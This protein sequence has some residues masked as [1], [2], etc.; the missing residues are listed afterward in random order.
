MPATIQDIA[1]KLKISKTTVH[2]ALS[3]TGR[4]SKK[5]EA[6][7][8]ETAQEVDYHPNDLARSMRNQK[9]MTI[10]LIFKDLK[11]GHFYSEILSGI[12]EIATKQGYVLN[13]SFSGN[14]P[15]KEKSAIYS[16]CQRRIDGLIIAPVNHSIL[17]N[18]TFLRNQKIPFVF[19]DKYVEEI[20]ADVIT[21]DNKIGIGQAVK[22]LMER[23]HTRIAFLSGSEYPSI[24]ILKRLQAYQEE[25]DH[26]HLYFKKVLYSEDFLGDD[27][28]CGY[29]AVNEY[30]S[31]TPKD[32]W[33][34]AMICVNDSLAFGAIRAIK[35]HNLSI[36]HDMAI[37]G[38]NNDPMS[39]FVS[40]RLT[41]LSQPKMEMGRAVSRLLL[42]R[43]ADSTENEYQF[44][45]FPMSLVIREST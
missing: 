38:I 15:Q 6:L 18:Y 45:S 10:G 2:R 21:A 25:L 44:K 11:V 22:H 42:N 40:P 5:T 14:D 3:G 32:D 8:L 4:I 29:Y 19:L 41:T 7:I 27:R 31:E 9:T 33:A 30:L 39:A 17:E 23:G 28:N 26:N 24:T 13:V 43:I 34:T 20:P 12:D 16:F 35:D 1:D 36:P 37:I